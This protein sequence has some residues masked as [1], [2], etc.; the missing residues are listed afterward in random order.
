MSRLT[1]PFVC[2]V[3][4]SAKQRCL[5]LEAARPVAD[6]RGGGS[7]EER[8]TAGASTLASTSSGVGGAAGSS[9]DARWLASDEVWADEDMPV[10]VCGRTGVSATLCV[11]GPFHNSMQGNFLKVSDSLTCVVGDSAGKLTVSYFGCIVKDN[12]DERTASTY[13]PP[14][15]PTRSVPTAHDP[16]LFRNPPLP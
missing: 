6:F 13:A 9:D 1:E 7:P 11:T 16:S 2:E 10:M 4:P 14:R 15:R 8:S 3:G 12:C 5:I